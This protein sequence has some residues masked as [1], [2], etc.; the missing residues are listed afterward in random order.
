MSGTVI[1]G[2]I[3]VLFLLLLFVYCGLVV[4]A[5]EDERMREMMEKNKKKGKK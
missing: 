3:L 5:R 4:A 1:V 2:I